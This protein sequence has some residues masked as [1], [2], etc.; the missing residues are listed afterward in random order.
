MKVGVAAS[1]Q[2]DAGGTWADEAQVA[3]A[4]AGGIPPARSRFKVW[5]DTA[6]VKPANHGMDTDRSV[7][8][9]ITDRTDETDALSDLD[10]IYMVP[11]SRI[12][13]G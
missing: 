8:V 3:V 11:G 9:T 13:D 10:V 1:L 5:R 6:T 4:G 2:E 7:V 12:G